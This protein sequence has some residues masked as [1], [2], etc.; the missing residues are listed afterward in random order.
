M[1][2]SNDPLIVQNTLIVV[3]PL[4]PNVL[5]LPEDSREK[6]TQPFFINPANI[7]ESIE[8]DLAS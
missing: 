7:A 1:T 4:L 6:T 2:E 8:S 5:P 3:R